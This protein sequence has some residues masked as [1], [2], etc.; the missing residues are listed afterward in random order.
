[1]PGVRAYGMT[2]PG[3]YPDVSHD[4][5]HAH[6]ALSSTGARRLTDP[7]CP[8]LFRYAADH[9]ERPAVEVLELG[10]AFHTLVFGA[11]P[12]VTTIPA[13][14]LAKNGAVST[15]AA[16]A[17]CDGVRAEG[18]IP[19]KAEKVA[20]LEAMAAVVRADPIFA[21]ATAAGAPEVS[22]FWTDLYG[23]ECRARFDWLPTRVKGRRLIVPDLKSAR[24]AHPRTFARTAATEHGYAQQADWYLRGLRALGLADDR[25][26]FVFFPQ[27]KTPPFLVQPVQLDAEAMRVG[28]ILNDR[29]I[30]TYARCMESGRWP[31]YHDGVALAQL[32]GWYTQ[33]V[34]ESV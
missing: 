7:S 26:A 28:E 16:K 1:M 3:I 2:A 12:A 30:E 11:G 27:E 29:A 14:V 15:T 25:A 20:L 6:P 18:G 34:L 9:P 24:S 21:A 5:Y 32:P 17:Y 33:P 23:V 31:G 19:L 13:D 4:D 10:Q 22:A 8:A